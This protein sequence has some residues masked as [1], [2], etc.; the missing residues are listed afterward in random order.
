MHGVCAS[1]AATKPLLSILSPKIDNPKFPV[2]HAV[3]ATA[4]QRAIV[5]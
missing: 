2:T 1:I 3:L 4:N 5:M